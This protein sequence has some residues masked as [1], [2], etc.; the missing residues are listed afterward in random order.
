MSQ[1]AAAGMLSAL[2]VALTVPALPAAAANE[3]SVEARL[4]VRGKA[5]R[6]EAVLVQ[7]VVH[8]AGRPERHIPGI[9]KVAIPPGGALKLGA[10]R[11]QF[12]GDST[13]WTQDLLVSVPDRPP[14][15]SIGPA[16]VVLTEPDGSKKKIVAQ[17]LRLGPT[18]RSQNLLGQGLGNSTVVALLLGLLGLRIR[19]LRGEEQAS[20]QTLLMQQTNAVA[21]YLEEG[22]CAT[23]AEALDAALA[24]RLALDRYDVQ[25]GSVPRS[26]DLGRR[27]DALKFGG[28]E[29]EPLA[30]QEDLKSLVRAGRLWANTAPGPSWK[31]GETK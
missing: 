6:G 9:P 24:L 29:P 14:P 26:E 4:L 28:E 15:W 12:T 31:R 20:L 16:R 2:F 1:R 27:A 21:A 23:S 13:S 30:C 19:R 18:R 17:T 10:S 11:S 22:E 8:W 3:D 7:L 25:N 5:R